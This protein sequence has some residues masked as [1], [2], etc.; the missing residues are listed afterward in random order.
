MN[1]LKISISQV[2]MDPSNET[3]T[4]VDI[5]GI[6]SDM[7]INKGRIIESCF[8]SDFIC[9]C[10]VKCQRILLNRSIL[11]KQRKTLMKKTIQLNVGS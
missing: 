2:Q 9:F 3:N 1:S 4:D 6:L 7:E 5:Q 8:S 11:M 10:L